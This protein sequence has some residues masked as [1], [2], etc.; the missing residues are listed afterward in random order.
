MLEN[1]ESKEEMVERLTREFR[2]LLKKRLPDEPG[3]L[4]EIER[5][6]EDI[7]TEIKREIEDECLGWHGSG[8]LGS[9]IVCSCGGVSKFKKYNP[10]RIVSQCGETTVIRAYYHCSSCRMSYVPLD[11]K[12]GLDGGCTSVG[13]R[14]KVAR[15][16][17]WI[18]FGDVSLELKELC[19]IHLSSNSAW[20]I[21]ES[22][23]ERIKKYRSQRERVILSGNVEI[24]AVAPGRLYIGIDGVHVPMCDG[25][26]H[27][28]KA[29]VVYQTHQQ[30]GKTKISNATYMATLERTE[31]FGEHVYALAFDLGVQ[32][33]DDVACLGDG[34]TWIWNSFSHH[35]PDAVQILDYYHASE[36]LDDV[37]KAWYGEDSD[38]A[39]CWLEARKLDLLS[40]CVET[41]IRSIR[42]WHPADEKAKEV[43]RVELGYFQK[44]KNRMLYATLKD[45][46]YHIGSGLVE[47]ACKTIVTQRLKQSGMRWS[48][49]G[50]EHMVHLRSFL[51]SNRSADI[52][53]FARA[54]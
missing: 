16:A 30:E 33:A 44:N 53:P 39:K 4:E 9:Q 54:A 43:R 17:A 12:L 21:A 31:A 46:G 10:K 20:R 19:G 52:A 35:Y 27:E 7:G 45:N 29:G 49:P 23:G 24:P 41:V 11:V 36:H 1:G 5:I 28:A 47:S 25:S 3:T 2:E 18:P 40:D 48:E 38:K 34:A 14:T 26:Y 13:V 37:A 51:M 50:A 6:T 15:L 22:V 32:K 8:Y 42:S